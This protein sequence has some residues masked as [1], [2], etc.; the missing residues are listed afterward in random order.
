MSASRHAAN[1]NPSAANLHLILEEASKKYKRL[2]GHD[3]TT[4]P[5]AAKLDNW[6]SVESVLKVF[7]EQ[8]QVFNQF[9]KDHRRLI[10]WLTPTVRTLITASAILGEALS[11]PFPPAKG[12]FVGIGVLLSAAADVVANYDILARLFERI[13]FFLQRLNIYTGIRLTSA[14]TELLGSIMAEIIL[15]LAIATK[16][17]TRRLTSE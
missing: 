5:F 11:V 4:H 3:L 13:Q 17:M 15:I 14:L 12:V 9:H 7:Q 10:E 6:D 2:T 16:E 8:A 1:G